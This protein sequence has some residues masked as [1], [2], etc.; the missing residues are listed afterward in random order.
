MPC[1]RNA[2]ES[3]V[4]R[5]RLSPN[6][7]LRHSVARIQ[8]PKQHFYRR[9]GKRDITVVQ[10]AVRQEQAGRRGI[11]VER[12]ST[13][14]GSACARALVCFVD[15]PRISRFVTQVR[16]VHGTGANRPLNVRIA[17]AA[18]LID[19]RHRR[20]AGG[21]YSRR[22]KGPRA[23]PRLQRSWPTRTRDGDRRLH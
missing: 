1:V 11:P 6:H 3:S 9:V 5:N 10:N 4:R 8:I 20:T 15:D 22:S 19:T 17:R 21:L 13:Q 16:L 23:T 14:R 18:S 7:A 12:A 2:L